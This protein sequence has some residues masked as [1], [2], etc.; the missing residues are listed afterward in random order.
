MPNATKITFTAVVDE[1]LRRCQHVARRGP[2]RT[3][4]KMR[5]SKGRGFGLFLL[6]ASMLAPPALAAPD[7]AAAVKAD[8]DK[9]LAAL[10]DHFHRNPE[11]SYKEVK[12]AARMAK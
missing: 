10:F 5:K 11:L 8:Y 6:A 7:F 4:V 9:S 2:E 1:A 12:T 3:E